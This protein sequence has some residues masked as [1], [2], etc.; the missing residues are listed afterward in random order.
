VS[1]GYE[2]SPWQVLKGEPYTADDVAM[3]NDFPTLLRMAGAHDYRAEFTS[4]GTK[5][6]V[7]RVLVV[8]QAM[9]TWET[10]Q[11]EIGDWGR[12]VVIEANPKTLALQVQLDVLVTP[13]RLGEM[14]RFDLRPTDQK[15]G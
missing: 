2:V 5:L 10:E 15:E 9:R 11:P 8:R 4:E 13:D 7:P 6:V 1:H 3:I 14:Y 12:R